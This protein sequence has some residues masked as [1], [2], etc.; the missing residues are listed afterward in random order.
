MP[1]ELFDDPGAVRARFAALR[2]GAAA[3]AACDAEESV[4]PALSPIELRGDSA[5]CELEVP[6]AAPF[7]ADHFPRRP[8]YPAS[9]LAFALS[10]L[11]APL[12]TRALAVTSS[13]MRL[14][15]LLD[16]KVRSFSPPGQRL[17]LIGETGSA[18]DG[19]IDIR[20]KASAAGQRV[21]TGVLEYR[22][23]TPGAT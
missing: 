9:L 19:V 1:M 15:R 3:G 2:S 5:A 7:F 4:R 21:A 14:A 12:A 8:V 13:A 20:V 18:R 11:G 6:D 23:V 22:R 17:E 16:Y 10:Q